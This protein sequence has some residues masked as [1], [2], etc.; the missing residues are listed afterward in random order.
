MKKMTKLLRGHDYIAFMDFEGTQFSHEMIAIGAIVAKVDKNGMIKK[1][2]EPFKMY[3]KAKNKI[4]H[5]V[6]NLTGITE[7]QLRKE[8]VSF[9][10]AMEAFKKYC[11]IP[12]NKHMSFITFGNHDMRIIGQSM[13]Y[14]LDGPKEICSVITKNFIDFSTYISEFCRD[15]N[16]NPMSLVHYCELFDVR[17]EGSAHDPEFDAVSLAYLYKAVMEQKSLLLE[18]YMKVLQKI[19]N[20]PAP[21]KKV[22]NRLAEGEN[23]TAEEFKNAAKEYIE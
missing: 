19:S 13:M 21:I 5:Y 4:G 10:T 9:R 20:I 11:G 3:V 17:V 6:T 8:G 15:A 23:V 18:E 14:N 16:Y 7:E 22:V 12:F 2:K 1:F